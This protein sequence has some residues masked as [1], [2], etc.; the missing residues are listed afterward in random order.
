MEAW[1]LDQNA[2]SLA[3]LDTFQS[4]I[5]TSLPRIRG[6][7]DLYAGGD[8]RPFLSEGRETISSPRTPTE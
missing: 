3:V 4:F 7:R 5:W 1:I 6:F 8:Q 2:A